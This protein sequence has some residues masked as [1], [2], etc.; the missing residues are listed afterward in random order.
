M[1]K[2]GPTIVKIDEVGLFVVACSVK[3]FGLDGL[4]DSEYN[5]GG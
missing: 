1:Y 2:D 3:I 5:L 4:R